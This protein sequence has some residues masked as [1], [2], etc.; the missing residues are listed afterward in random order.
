MALGSLTE[1]QNQLLIVKDVG[2]I[3]KI[4][5]E[6]ISQQTVTSHKLINGLIKSLKF[7]TTYY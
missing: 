4:D 6:K 2:Y 5:F 3:N 7:H 1:L